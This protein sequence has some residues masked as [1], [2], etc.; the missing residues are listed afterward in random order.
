MPV[1]HFDALETDFMAQVRT[2]GRELRG[3]NHDVM[4]GGICQYQ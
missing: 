4:G 1:L 2:D 3:R